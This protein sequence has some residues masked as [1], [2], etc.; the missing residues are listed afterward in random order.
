MIKII[1]VSFTKGGRVYYFDPGE[2]ELSKN[3]EVI[4]ETEK[5]LQYGYTE[6]DIVSINDENLK[7][8]LKPVIRIANEN[9]KNRNKK[10]NEKADKALIKAK[11]C[12][13]KEDLKMNLID[14]KFT[15]DQKQLIF[16]FTSDKRIDFRNLAK[17]LAGIYHTRIELRQIGVRDKAREVG[18]IGVCGRTLCCLN[19]K[20]NFNTVSIN[21]AKNQNLSLNPSKINGVCGRLKC[22]LRYEDPVYR[23]MRKTLPK[24]GEKVKTKKG[25]GTVNSVNVLKQTY[26]VYVPKIGVIEESVEDER[27]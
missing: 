1:N 8:S 27:D 21:M 7:A 4:V 10:N 13:A 20:G 19:C 2:L 12:A 9:D 24:V 16:H 25:E 3:M 22:C 5:G 11:E 23:E 26:L 14:A 17:E 15:F 6:T 18:G